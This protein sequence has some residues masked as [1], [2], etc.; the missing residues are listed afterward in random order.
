MSVSVQQAKDFLGPLRGLLSTFVLKDRP[1]GIEFCRF[2]FS[3]VSAGS[4]TFTVFDTDAFFAS[5]SDAIAGDRRG[6]TAL[7]LFIP[8]PGS[9]PQE[10]VPDFLAEARTEFLLVENINSLFRLFSS[11]DRDSAGQKVAFT[12]AILSQFARTNG[13][14]VLSTSYPSARVEGLSR[15]RPLADL[16]DATIPVDVQ[17]SGVQF[18]CKG[19]SLWPGGPYLWS[20]LPSG[21]RR[22]SP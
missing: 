18:R 20:S 13:V 2:L 19:R 9:D 15:G 11:D 5:N 12:M 17:P 1:A 8:E 14:G 16:A 21:Q 22:R 10:A 6:G 4:G 7:E 3:C